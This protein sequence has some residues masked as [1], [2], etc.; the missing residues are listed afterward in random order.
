MTTISLDDYRAKREEE[1]RLAQKPDR[2][3]E[4]FAQIQAYVRA[5]RLGDDA[6][7]WDALEEIEDGPCWQCDLDGKPDAAVSTK[8]RARRLYGALALCE[9]CVSSR[10]IA[11][12]KSA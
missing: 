5:M 11:K 12:R 8:M 9:H 7:T 1:R 6:G 10:V 3:D 2:S 4:V